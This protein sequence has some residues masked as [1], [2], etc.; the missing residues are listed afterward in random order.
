MFPDAVLRR[1]VG[2][3]S[4]VFVLFVHVLDSI[5]TLFGVLAGGFSLSLVSV[6][7]EHLLATTLAGLSTVLDVGTVTSTYI[8][9][10]LIYLGSVSGTGRV[11]L[12]VL[13]IAVVVFGIMG[14]LQSLVASAY[15]IVGVCAFVSIR[16]GV[17]DELLVGVAID[18]CAGSESTIRLLIVAIEDPS[19]D[20]SP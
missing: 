18:C 7:N 4:C 8:S 9:L 11:L 17:H 14:S 19:F 3:V 15:D 20:I 2:S 6:L 16:L 12:D 13:F 1:L 10:V 5:L